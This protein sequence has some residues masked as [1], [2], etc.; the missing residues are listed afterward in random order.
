L[1][2][3]S[4]PAE[5]RL[6]I[7]DFVMDT[8]P[9]P[10]PVTMYEYRGLILSCRQINAE[11]EAEAVKRLQ[12]SSDRVHDIWDRPDFPLTVAKPTRLSDSMKVVIG[13]PKQYFLGPTDFLHVRKNTLGHLVAYLL[14]QFSRFSIIV[15]DP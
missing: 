11:F 6:Q 12:R 4:I 13:L 5:L 14:T 7:Y 2:F 9:T 15:T 8:T 1:S 3:L 10:R